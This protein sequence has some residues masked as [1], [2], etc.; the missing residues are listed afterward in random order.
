MAIT[1]N[2]DLKVRE[3]EFQS[4]M[5]ESVAQFINGVIGA[6]GGAITM[7][8]NVEGG[9]FHKESFYDYTGLVSRRTTTS[10]SSIADIALTQ[11]DVVGVKLSRGA[12]GA[13]TF[14]AMR[15][16]G[17]DMG[18]FS[19]ILGQQYAEQKLQDMLNTGLIALETCIQDGSTTINY[20]ATAG[21]GAQTLQSVD[22]VDGLAKFGDR[23][24]DILCWVMHS[25]P[26]FDLVKDQI[27]QKIPGNANLVLYGASPASLGRPI[28]VTDS[29]ALT[30]ANA[31]LDDTYNVLGLTRGALRIV[32]SES[33][34]IV[35]DTITGLGNLVMRWQAEY[36]YTVIVK[37]FAYSTGAGANPAD[38]TLG[39]TS[40]WAT[41][42]TSLRHGPGI[43]VVCE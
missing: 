9:H 11:D 31:S 17:K 24:G 5:Y 15:K 27:G 30:D 37:G 14:D 41:V 35:T 16:L 32:E 26:A 22:L 1:V 43:R 42:L 25:K 28:I 10:V 39:N 13:S 36:S 38:S 20:D 23:A 4:G 19:F 29:P 6:T 40:S 18:E 3:P 21:S 2:T 8:S 7:T 12:R 34:S 33:E